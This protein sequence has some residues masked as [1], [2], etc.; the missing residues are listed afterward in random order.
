MRRCDLRDLVK[1]FGADNLVFVMPCRPVHSGYP[2]PL[3]FEYSSDEEVPNVPFRLAADE[4]K[5]QDL[6][7]LGRVPFLPMQPGFGVQHKY[8]SD[9]MH[10]LYNWPT[11][12]KVGYF[13]ADQYFTIINFE[14]EYA[15]PF[16]LQLSETPFAIDCP[17]PGFRMATNA[18]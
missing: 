5:Y 10:Y 9:L 6:A 4:T 13:D 1:E 7:Y 11:H 18:P 8:G 15:K 2:L 3:G 16:T 14:D 17:D 12:Y